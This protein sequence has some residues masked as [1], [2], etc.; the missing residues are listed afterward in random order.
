MFSAVPAAV[1]REAIYE[2]LLKVF[3]DTLMTADEVATRF[4][5]R[6]DTL[7]NMRRAGKGPRWI[8]FESGGIRYPSSG[9]VA[10]QL[11][12]HAGAIDIVEVE[13]AITAAT[14]VPEAYRL[15]ML[16]TV[17]RALGARG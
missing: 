9:V 4:R 10:Y 6:D 8:K 1:R 5:Y 11:A 3:E 15:K 12:G 16:E 7:C 17:R 2:P 14:D 13:L